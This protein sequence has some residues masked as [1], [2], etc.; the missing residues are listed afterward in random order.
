MMRLANLRRLW[1][2]P[3]LLSLVTWG[4]FCPPCRADAIPLRGTSDPRVRFVDYKADEVFTIAVALGVVTR[5]VLGPDEQITKVP[6]S[7]F[8]ASCDESTNEWCIRADVGQNQITVKPRRGATRNN[9][10]VSTNKRDYSFSLVKMDGAENARVVYYRVV[11]RYAMPALPAAH[12]QVAA[13]GE[14]AV[15]IAKA[16]EAKL[17]QETQARARQVK[18]DAAKVYLTHQVRNVSYS[19]R[20]EGGARD[21]LPSVVFDDGRYTYFKFPKA[22]AVPGVFSADANGDESREFVHSER[23]LAD[24]FA[25]DDAVESDY[26]VVHRVAPKW[27]LRLGATVAEVINDRYDRE[28]VETHNGTTT[29]DIV[30]EVK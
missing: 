14:D 3:A 27:R 16:A 20:A 18:A 28:G 25:P 26:L 19:F 11:F 7:G 15:Q 2:A 8:P 4:L 6:D 12:V 24:P 21:L 9:L 13:P 22:T 29:P 10:E 17:A 23:L 1:W 30:R 5:I